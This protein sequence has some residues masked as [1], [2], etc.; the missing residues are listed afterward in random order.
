MV[1]PTLVVFRAA[2]DLPDDVN[3]SVFM[4]EGKNADKG[5]CGALSRGSSAVSVKGSSWALNTSD[6]SVHLVRQ[7]TALSSWKSATGTITLF[8][9]NPAV[10]FPSV[11]ALNANQQYWFSENEERVVRFQTDPDQ[12]PDD[13]ATSL[14]VSIKRG[15]D[16]NNSKT[17]FV[18]LLGY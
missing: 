4:R 17:F 11:R 16:A 8:F 9:D 2:D 12:F 7:S 10:G 15:V 6:V 13:I 3:I 1:M 14:T 5:R 18:K